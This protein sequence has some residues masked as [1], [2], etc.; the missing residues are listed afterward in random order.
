MRAANLEHDDSNK[1]R[2]LRKGL[3][4]ITNS[5]V[6][7]KAVV[8]LATKSNDKDL[9]LLLQRAVDCCPQLMELWLA[10][11]KLET[12]ELKRP[13]MILAKAEESGGGTERAWM[14][15]AIDEKG[16]GNVE[17][18]RKLLD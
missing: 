2:V 5:V 9:I 12:C 10:Q 3:E 13:R 6:L 15:S 18:E 11:A 17:D 14:K 1:T 16:L 7:W 4:R 8:E